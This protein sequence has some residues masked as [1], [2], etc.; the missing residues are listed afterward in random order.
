VSADSPRVRVNADFRTF[1]P[2]IDYCATVAT[3]LSYVPAKYLTGLDRVVL[4]DR[5]GLVR[6]EKL[7]ERKMG[8]RRGTYFRAVANRPAHIELFVDQIVASWPAALLRCRGIREILVS[9]TLYHEVGHHIHGHIAPEHRDREAVAKEWGLRLGRE[10]MR[11]RYWYL[12]P[13]FGPLRFMLSR[14][15]ALLWRRREPRAADRS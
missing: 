4:R 5:G 14:I 2:R 15:H 7:R 11:R 13:F 12:R 10:Y 1:A 8:V 3:L 6:K 9:R